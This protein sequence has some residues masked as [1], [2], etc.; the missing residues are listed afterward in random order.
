MKKAVL[1]LVSF[2]LVFSF[3][4]ALPAAA[5]ESDMY[6]VNVQIL[7][8]FPLH[9]GYYVI[10]RRA[11]LKTGE[12]YIPN[13]W[14]D[15]RDQRAVLNLTNNSVS[16]YLS[17]VYRNGEFDHVR[18]MASKDLQNPTWG[19]MVERSDQPDKFK[20]EKLDLQF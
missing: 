1:L 15:R 11:G 9:E 14:L 19:T 7:K 2:M 5:E 10:Y 3:V 12:A 17:I 20:I 13:A 18:I 4:A 8:I 6:Y 16:P